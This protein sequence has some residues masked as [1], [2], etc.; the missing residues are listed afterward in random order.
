MIN[1]N[2]A[3]K[4]L[5]IG[6]YV[7]N[8]AN[9]IIQLSH[10]TKSAY[11]TH[12]LDGE[13][14]LEVIDN[15]NKDQVFIIQ[16]LVND[17]ALMSLLVMI[18]AAKRYGVQDIVVIVPYLGYAR[19]DRRIHPCSP[20]S[21]KLIAKLLEVAGSNR[22]IAIDIHNLAIEGFFDI[23]VTNI[24]PTDLFLQDIKKNYNSLHDVQIIAPDVGAVKRVRKIAMQLGISKVAIID[25]HRAKAGES[26]VMNIIGDVTNKNCIIIDDIVDSAGTLC[27]AS[28]ALKERGAKT[29]DAYIT[30][31]VFAGQSSEASHTAIAR[32]DNSQLS[33]LIIT[34]ST[35]Y[36]A[37]Q[38]IQYYSSA[39]S[40]TVTCD[41]IQIMSLAS[42]I[43]QEIL[44]Y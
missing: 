10:A 13:A 9:E 17:Q 2:Q 41:K 3:P 5:F 25:K 34:N 15:P 11:S 23:P 38:G 32:V 12:F 33:R 8:V 21:A 14:S 43:A 1:T 18:D 44:N 4:S 42:I 36:P 40:K 39:L 7:S 26:E 20:I 28:Q 22:L 31:G 35:T 16:S 19:Q 29:V 37:G 30:H 24:L 27:N 6:D